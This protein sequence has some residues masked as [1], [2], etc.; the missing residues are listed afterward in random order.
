MTTNR[1]LAFDLGH[2]PAFGRDDFLV[3]PGN[4]EAVAQI[5]TWPNWPTHALAIFGPAG[6]GKSHLAHVFALRSNAKVIV[7][8][9]VTTSAVE[10]L[11]STQSPLI[12][13]DGDAVSDERALLHVFNAVKERGGHILFTSREPPSRWAVKLPDLKS[14]LSSVQAVRIEMP[15]D[16]MIEAVIVKLF[17]DRQI[18]ISPDVVKYMV[19]NMDR[20]FAAARRIVDLADRESLT[21]KRPVTIPLVKNILKAS[22]E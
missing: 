1:Q 18:E 19:R 17:A 10:N 21:G 7:P 22:S 13:E 20:T 12:I 9:D 2:R 5:D 16:A 6:C 4:Q 11:I 15:D 3:A 8:S 14:R